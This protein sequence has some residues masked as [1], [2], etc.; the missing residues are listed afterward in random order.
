VY[1]P[2]VQDDMHRDNKG[3]QCLRQGV[4]NVSRLKRARSRA[5]QQPAKATDDRH[6]LAGISSILS[7]SLKIAPPATH[8]F[9]NCL[10]S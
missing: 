1:A 2:A 10:E 9:C 7:N 5:Q 4:V 6:H 8:N 3:Q